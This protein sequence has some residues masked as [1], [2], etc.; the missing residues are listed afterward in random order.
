M[1]SFHFTIPESDYN[2]PPYNHVHHADI[3]RYLEKGREEYVAHIGFPLK[4]LH[5]RGFFPVVSSL[6][7]RYLRELKGGEVL[8]TSK[9]MSKERRLFLIEQS[10]LN[11]NSKTAISAVVGLMFINIESRLGVPIPVDFAEALI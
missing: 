4:E 8:I 11:P 6:D 10:I 2:N 3:I 9:L 1:F 5:S 7:I